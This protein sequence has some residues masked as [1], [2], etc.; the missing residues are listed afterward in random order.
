MHHNDAE[1]TWQATGKLSSLLP[2]YCYR[3]GQQQFAAYFQQQIACGGHLVIEA[4]AGIGKTYAYL[5]PILTQSRRAVIAT[6]SK[7]LQ[8]QLYYKD[9]PLLMDAFSPDKRAVLLKGRS[10]YLCPLH[11]ESNLK[12]MRSLSKERQYIILSLLSRWRSSGSGELSRLMPAEK[13]LE[14]QPLVISNSDECQNQ[15]CKYLKQC[16]FLLQREQAR[17]ADIV[18]TNQ[19]VLIAELQK[20]ETQK[21]ELQRREKKKRE[22]HADNTLLR[23]ED[24][25]VVDEAHRLLSY[26]EQELSESWSS[27]LCKQLLDE[28]ETNFLN[29]LAD[30]SGFRSAYQQARRLMNQLM[31]LSS[32]RLSVANISKEQEGFVLN[33]L[34][35][36][37]KQLG[38]MQYAMDIQRDRDQR[39]PEFLQRFSRL[40]R[41]LNYWLALKQG[42]D[43]GSQQLMGMERRGRHLRL[44]LAPIQPDRLIKQYL[45]SQYCLLL[46]SATLTRR[47][48][49]SCA[50]RDF[51]ADKAAYHRIDS[52]FDYHQQ[53]LLLKLPVS[54]LPDDES[55]YI[56]ML[57]QLLP[58]IT[59]P[60][61]KFL[62]LVTSYR[63]LDNLVSLIDQKSSCELFLPHKSD[64]MQV[65]RDFQSA[66]GGVLL[67]TASFWEGVDLA[68]C[69]ISG[70][71]VDRL[72]FEAPNQ[73]LM[74]AKEQYYRDQGRNFFTEYQLP[75]ACQRLSQA[76]GR[77]IRKETD[78]GVFVV[79]DPR[80]YT[81]WYG[82]VFLENLPPMAIERNIEKV[83]EFLEKHE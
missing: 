5:V 43:C 16:P 34:N 69:G 28:L 49:E 13:L 8:D 66:A 36:I 65:I 7:L 21:R 52:P 55:Y 79:V 15:H 24:I 27:F 14:V 18:I 42:G 2:D 48:E 19:H 81:K 47:D 56:D 53:S 6:A 40:N 72:P 30:H 73:A 12:N 9:L 62:F 3:P 10:N 32:P 29:T 25:L 31:Q 57:E 83:K 78:R 68:D 63:A 64:K 82:G 20:R 59:L 11:A 45:H 1:K 70:I 67:A 38:R 75:R 39:L 33:T 26:A 4:P 51:V 77:L 58:L 23:L 61:K 35:L 54:T 41:A 44:Q 60:G 50:E 71:I 80:L 76:C 74:R 37:A 22:K 46:T 17:N